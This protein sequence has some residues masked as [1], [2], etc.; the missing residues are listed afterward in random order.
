[1][2]QQLL[3]M[4]MR[5][6]GGAG[7]NFSPRKG[8]K[9][10]SQ[11]GKKTQKPQQK[12]ATQISK[13][14]QKPQQKVVS[15]FGKQ[16]QKQQPKVL[17]PVRTEA[18]LQF[19]E[20]IK[21]TDASLKVWVGGLTPGFDWKKLQKHFQN[22]A[23][24]KLVH[25]YD[26]GTAV[27]TFDS[28]EKV[29]DAIAALNGSK[30]DGKTIECD[31]WTKPE[32]SDNADRA[33]KPRKLKPQLKTVASKQVKQK[34]VK[35]QNLKAAAKPKVDEKML[36]KLKEVDHSLKMW[37]GGLAKSTTWKALRQHFVQAGAK[38]KLV[39]INEK[40]Q[41]GV[42]TFAD[43]SDV[44]DAIGALSGSELDGNVIEVD[45]WTKPEKKEKKPKA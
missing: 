25:V 6:A 40:R 42:A 4:I 24:P 3:S 23:K 26:K 12:F 2:Q 29:G 38:P 16:P 18:Q 34:L 33:K 15:K 13:K 31:V 10:V 32:K 11:I 28:E 44:Q 14:P 27:V 7:K 9:I 5:Q 20:K 1:M 30:L 35:Q 17:K 8:P 39:H 37:V 22:V 41:T 21:E 43:E 19:L 36:Q 45:V